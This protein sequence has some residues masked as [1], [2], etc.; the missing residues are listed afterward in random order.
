MTD[1]Q[2][3]SLW[4]LEGYFRCGDGFLVT[5]DCL[6]H[7]FQSHTASHSLSITLP[8][9]NPDVDSGW[10]R[11]QPW[12]FVLEGEDRNSVSTEGRDWGDIAGGKKDAPIYA[13]IV[14]CAVHSEVHSGGE[15]QFTSAAEQFGDELAVW[16]TLVCD[17]ARRSHAA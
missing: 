8:E 4:P 3:D 17:L 6:A 13:H 12:K 11:H 15:D 2:S 16:W 1:P 14:Q 9:I 5:P 10:L 7:T